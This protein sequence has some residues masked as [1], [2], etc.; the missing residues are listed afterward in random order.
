MFLNLIQKMTK[1]QYEY[2]KAGYTAQDAPS[3]AYF[4]PSKITRDGPT[5]RRTDGRTDGRTRPHIE[6]RRRI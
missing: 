4:S 5:D 1:I 6:M 2:N 3:I